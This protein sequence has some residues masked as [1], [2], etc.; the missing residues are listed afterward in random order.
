MPDDRTFER[1]REVVDE[2][3]RNG[4]ISS[5]PIVPRLAHDLRE[6]GVDF[7]MN[8]FQRHNGDDV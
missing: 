1:L 6:R 2:L 8:I 3:A 5:P 4:E 7:P